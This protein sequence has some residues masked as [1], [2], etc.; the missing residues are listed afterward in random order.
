M[1]NAYQKPYMTISE[2]T[3]YGLSRD[4][5]VQLAHARGAP[6]MRT[7]GGRKRGGRIYFKTSELDEFI[8]EVTKRVN[9]LR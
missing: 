1:I 5:L 2:L 6:I 3:Q 8:A 9:S 7:M 4:Y